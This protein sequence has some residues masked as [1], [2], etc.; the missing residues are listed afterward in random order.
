MTS[1]A[2]AILESRLQRSTGNLLNIRTDLQHFALINYAL[3]KSRL[4]PHIPTDR[5]DIPEFTI[6]GQPLAMLSAVPFVDADFRYSRLTPWLKFRFGQTN[7]R[8]YVIDKRTGQPVEDAG[9]TFTCGTEFTVGATDRVKVEAVTV[10]I[11]VEPSTFR[12]PIWKL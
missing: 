5:F 6:N 10:M 4:E 9:I 7:H 3:P 8:V 1:S 12:L 2:R 11:L